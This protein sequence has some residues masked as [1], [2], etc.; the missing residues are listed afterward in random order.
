MIDHSVTVRQLESA[1]DAQKSFC[2]MTEVP[3]PWPDALCLCRDW[4]SQNLG[5]YVEGYHLQLESGEVIGHLYYAPSERALFPYEMET[6]LVVLYCEWV[7]QQYQKQGLGRHLFTA[8]ADDMR[9]SGA[10]GILVEGS[11]IE[12]Q[13]HFHHYL[14]RGFE[15]VSETGHRKLLYLPLTQPRVSVQPM[16][17]RIHPR[18]GTPVEILILNS[19][20]C[21]HDVSTMMLLR[22][23]SREFGDQISLREVSITPDSLREFGVARGFFINGRQKLSGGE[24]EEAIRQA[25]AEEL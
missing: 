8:F 5:Q 22:Q 16:E 17:P 23:V 10:K 1:D 6:N 21:P 24:T 3:T 9:Q 4:V 2:C 14:A 7:Q 11:D 25:I 13:M 18:Y 15:I 20:M 19:Y 12:G